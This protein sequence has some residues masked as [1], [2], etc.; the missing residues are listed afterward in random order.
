L[1]D[2]VEKASLQTKMIKMGI[3]KFFIIKKKACFR[4]L[5]SLFGVRVRTLLWIFRKSPFGGLGKTGL[6]ATVLLV[7]NA[8]LTF[9][10]KG[11]PAG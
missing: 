1:N 7:W 10:V 3:M 5:Y 9:G 11:Q 2:G 8:S 6:C 4:L